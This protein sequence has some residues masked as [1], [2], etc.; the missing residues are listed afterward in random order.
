LFYGREEAVEIDVKEGE[1]IGLSERAHER[2]IFA[3]YSP[4]TTRTLKEWI[5]G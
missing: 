1:E 5:R 2:I 3:S 4:E